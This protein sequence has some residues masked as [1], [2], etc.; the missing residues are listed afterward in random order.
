[1]VVIIGTNRL[2]DCETV[3]LVRGD[4]LLR[5]EEKP[6]RLTVITPSDIPSGRIVRVIGN[7]VEDAQG[8]KEI[9]HVKVVA[10]DRS[11]S[12]FWDTFLLVA[13]TSI[14]EGAV[15]VHIDF[16]PIGLNMF[17]DPTGLHLGGMHLAQSSF[18][19]SATAF[20]FG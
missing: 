11:V 4:P 16:R 3:I 13:A 1:V 9:G 8:S 2:V 20:S 12:I 14:E 6:L 17:D 5:V 10:T 7:I 19:N 15:N 18:H